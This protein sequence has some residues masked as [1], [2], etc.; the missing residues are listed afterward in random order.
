MATKIIA[1][2]DKFKQ[3]GN[4]VVQYDPHHFALPW[5]GVRFLL[6]VQ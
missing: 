3:V 1:W 4:M 6:E 2:L 5:A